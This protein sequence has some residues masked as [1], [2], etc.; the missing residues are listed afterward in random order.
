ML[1]SFNRV[2]LLLYTWL[3]S[4]HS[5]YIAYSSSTIHNTPTIGYALMSLTAVAVL[6]ALPVLCADVCGWWDCE[7]KSGSGMVKKRKYVLG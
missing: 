7:V 1:M 2:K 5:V 6:K 3:A 4:H